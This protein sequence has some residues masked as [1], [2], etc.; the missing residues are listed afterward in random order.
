MKLSNLFEENDMKSN[1]ERSWTIL[2]EDEIESNCV[3]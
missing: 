2:N 1:V 3:T